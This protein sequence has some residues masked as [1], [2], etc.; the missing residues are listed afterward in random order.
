ME[1]LT[2][3]DL[4]LA[5]AGSK[6]LACGGGGEVEWA[7]PLMKALEEEG[8]EVRI[9][10]Q[11]EIKDEDWLCVP[12]G[13][14]AGSTP[15]VRERLKG[16][17]QIAPPDRLLPE[18][19]RRALEAFERRMGVEFDKFLP[20]NPGPVL[21]GVP[22]YLAAL[23][24]RPCV[25]GDCAGRAIPQWTTTTL[26]VKEIAMTPSVFVSAYGDQVTIDETPTNER[27]EEVGRPVAVASGGWG[28]FIT[29]AAKGELLRDAY[30]PGLIRKAKA[31]GAAVED[32]RQ[33]G[34]DPVDPC[35]EAAAGLILF[36]GSVSS[37]ERKEE[38]GFM[39]GEIRVQGSESYAGQECE[40]YQKSEY[41]IAWVDGE[42]AA[43]CPDS[44][45]VIDGRT[46]EGLTA[47]PDK[48]VGPFAPVRD[49]DFQVGRE[50]VV[51][52]IPAHPIWQTDRGVRL[53]GPRSLGFD[54]DYVP[55]TERLG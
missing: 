40:I 26:H 5:F 32:A 54:I 48:S 16:V 44:I 38:E 7:E 39:Y 33:R 49:A 51:F 36:R 42:V 45:C 46:A 9:A 29:C 23:R 1:T 13:L 11:D 30:V 4:R 35:L 34:E 25:D 8:L 22:M 20:V 17:P 10:S 41:S 31:I 55:V 50:I 43:T 12:G 37:Y 3:E 19:A 53:F 28:L 2:L 47:F 52:G 27:M 21:W 18:M 14:G 15:E 6:V 24:G